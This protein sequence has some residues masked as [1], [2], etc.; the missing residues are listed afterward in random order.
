MKVVVQNGASHGLSRREAEALVELLP[1]HFARAAESLVLYRGQGQAPLVKHY[2]KA[3]IIG[4]FWPSE[5]RSSQLKVE[6]VRELLVS[7]HLIVE[8]GRLPARVSKARKAVAEAAIDALLQE[9]VR[10]LELVASNPSIE[11]TSS[12]RLRLPT[13]AAHVER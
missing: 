11:R 2:Q 4:L 10:A 12:G 5:P 9:C 8:T 7:L 13:A 6:A 1:K 3:S